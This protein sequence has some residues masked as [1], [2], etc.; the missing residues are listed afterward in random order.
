MIDDDDGMK[1]P[2]AIAI[3]TVTLLLSGGVALAFTGSEAPTSTDSTET[4]SSDAASTDDESSDDESTE[5]E[6]DDT[7]S[8]DAEDAEDADGTSASSDHPDNHGAA[9]SQAAHDCPPGPGHGACVSA[10]AHDHGDASN[11]D[12]PTA[13]GHA[14]HGQGG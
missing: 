11:A 10:V 9:V 3:I 13:K 5:S 14:K 12:A 2:V 4:S 8:S 6:S 7:E 1:K